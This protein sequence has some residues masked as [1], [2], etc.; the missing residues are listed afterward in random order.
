MLFIKGLNLNH[1]HSASLL[2][3][4]SHLQS[5]DY[6]PHLAQALCS[7]A[8]TEQDGLSALN[9]TLPCCPRVWITGELW[10]PHV[11]QGM[12]CSGSDQFERK[13]APSHCVR[14]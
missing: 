5:S 4:E 3:L 1:Q 12:M 14:G 8:D 7:S 6:L 13:K 10:I 11:V 9:T 2:P